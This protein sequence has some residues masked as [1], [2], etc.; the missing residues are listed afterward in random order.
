MKRLA[1]AGLLLAVSPS[2]WADCHLPLTKTISKDTAKAMMAPC[3]APLQDFTAKAHAGAGAAAGL[4]S[5]WVDDSQASLQDPLGGVYRGR[6]AIQR[7]F[8]GSVFTS[9]LAGPYKVVDNT[10]VHGHVKTAAGYETEDTGIL[11]WDATIDNAP[12]GGKH[13]VRAL[14]V[15]GAD[16]KWLFHT[17]TVTADLTR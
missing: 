10:I 11:E 13:H 4:A 7:A 16:K 8:D 2:V 12:G 1:L 14:V 3:L 9:L 15:R 17:V 5:L 6:A